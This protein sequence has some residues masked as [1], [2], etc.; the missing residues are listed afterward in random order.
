[1]AVDGQDRFLFVLNPVSDDIS[2][3]QIDQASGALSEVPGSPFAFPPIDPVW[4]PPSHPL[5]L[6]AERSGQFLFVSYFYANGG[7]AC[8]NQGPSAVASFAIDTSGTNPILRPVASIFP[9]SGGSPVRLLT[10]SKGLYL[11]VGIGGSV[12]GAPASG[13]EVYL[14]DGMGNLL[15]QGIANNPENFGSDYAIDPRDRFVYAVGGLSAEYML[16]CIISPVDGTTNNCGGLFLLGFADS[17]GMLVEGSG[18]FLYIPQTSSSAAVYS[19]DQTTGVPTQVSSLTGILLA[20]G[21]SA[22]DPA[23]PYIYAADVSTSPGAVHA[24]LVDQ[25]TGNLSEV[26]GSPFNPGA[27][28]CCQGLAISGNPAQAISGPAAT[29][30]PS[31][32]A[33]FSATVGTISATQIFSLVNQGNQLLAINSISITGTGASSFSQTN[34]CL[35]PLA[36]N[37]HC[38]ISINFNPATAGTFTASLQVA[39]NAPGSPQTL[40]LNGTGAS[41]EPDITLSPS[42]LS[43]PLPPF[44]ATTQ[45][46]SSSPLTITVLSVGTAPLHIATVSLAGPNPTDFSFTNNCTAPVAPSGNCTISVVFSPIAAGQR[47]ANLMVSDDASGSPETVPLS[48]TAVAAFSAGAVPGGSTIASV[49]AGQPALYQLQL[50]PGPGFSGTISL[51]CSGAPLAAVCQ[52]PASVA[53][54]SPTATPFTVT[55]TTSG[56]ALLPPLIPVRLP[57]ISGAPLLPFVAFALMLACL[58]GFRAPEFGTEKNRLAVCGLLAAVLSAILGVTGCGGGSAAVAPPPPIVTPSGTST[59]VITPSAMSVSGQPL[60]LQ[61]IQLTLTVK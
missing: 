36:P 25:Q 10:D 20:K 42:S 14:I 22:A 47:T 57:P 27:S 61:P 18:R 53:L 43:F 58:L 55:V 34:T 41:P 23:G 6:A 5:S 2:M 35:V 45:G 17:G 60:Q 1:M 44:A 3:F 59:I 56:S 32:A 15:Y 54:A 37:A 9:H 12:N 11:Y 24:Y 7:D 38:S 40:L 8:C 16:S 49:S 48:G 51:T 46:T 30:F 50:T 19:I 33:G 52:V 26:P 21:N 4:L 29:I 39:D 31:I 28:A 13:P